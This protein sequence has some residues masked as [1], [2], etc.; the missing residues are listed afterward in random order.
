MSLQ[1]CYLIPAVDKPTRVSTSARLIDNIFVNV[2]KMVLV[3]GNIISEIS[4][5]YTP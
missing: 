4:D 5:H 2:P 1:S 3:S